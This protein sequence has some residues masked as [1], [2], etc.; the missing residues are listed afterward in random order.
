MSE[1]NTI[2]LVVD[3]LKGFL[4][5]GN[6]FCGKEA[7]KIIPHVVELLKSSK[8]KKIFFICDSHDENDREFKMFPP[9]CIKGTEESKVIDELSSFKGEIIPKKRYS[10]FF[11]TS[12]EKRLLEAKPDKVIVVGVCTDICVLYTVADLRSRDYTVEVPKK[13]VA[14]F[15]REAHKFALK[16]IEKILGATIT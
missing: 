7:R 10:G 14:S 8:R 16:H 2:I 5:K 12:F 1:E 11:N 3:M 15:D 4:E 9:H 13:C 6:L